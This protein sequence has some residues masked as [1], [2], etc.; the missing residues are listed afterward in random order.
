[1][2]IQY[3]A[4]HRQTAGNV[5]L[6]SDDDPNVLDVLRPILTDANYNVVI[7]SGR[8]QALEIAPH[9]D[10]SVAILDL[11]MP[12]GDGLETC[13]ALR[14][15]PNW[16]DVPMLILTSYQTDKA[17]RA[18]GAPGISDFLCKPFVPSELLRRVARAIGDA[19]G[20]G[21]S[22]RMARHRDAPG[23][24]HAFN[25]TAIK[26]RRTRK[27]VTASNADHFELRQRSRQTGGDVAQP[28]PKAAPRPNSD[29]EPPSKPRILVADDDE[30]T[31]HVVTNILGHEGYIAHGVTDGREAVAAVTRDNYDLVLMDVRMPVLGGS[32]A[33]RM[34]RALPTPKRFVPV[35]AMTTTNFTSFTRELIKAGMNDYLMK[36]IR[37]DSLL[38]CLHDHLAPEQPGQGLEILDFDRLQDEVERS[39]LGAVS[40][41]SDDLVEAINAIVPVIQGWMPATPKEFAAG[42]HALS[43]AARSLA[44]D[45]LADAA[46]ALETAASPSEEIRKRFVETA[47]ATLVVIRRIREKSAFAEVG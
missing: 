39:G 19:V 23:D 11:S 31:R 43:D 33:T 35:I 25:A 42:L 29:D 9:V 1:L 16:R 15:L 38:A 37:P 3:S 7:A 8:R 17:L 34:I 46:Q 21:A 41:L 40:R 4:R 45:A 44:C 18:T 2:A 30:L 26:A 28:E 47:R 12:G 14:R 20:S 10:A 5:A 24:A 36:P 22:E 6:I 32:E 13:A 27:S